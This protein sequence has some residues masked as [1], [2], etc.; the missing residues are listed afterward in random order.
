[1]AILH[2]ELANELMLVNRRVNAGM[3][4]EQALHGMWERTGVSELRALVANMIQSERWGT[5]IATV[6]RV[7]AET[8]RR[9]RKQ[10]AEKAAATAPVKMLFPLTVFIFPALLVVI[11]GPGAIKILETFRSIGQ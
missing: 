8:L 10:M 7:Y 2:P 6:L 1:M 9:K 11:L 3:P 5:S 4:R